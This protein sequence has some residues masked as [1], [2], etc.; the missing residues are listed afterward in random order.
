[1]STL[2]MADRSIRCPATPSMMQRPVTGSFSK[3]GSVIGMTS[4]GFFQLWPPVVDLISVAEPSRLVP[5]KWVKNAYTFPSLSV[6]TVQPS[7]APWLRLVCGGATWW[8]F[9]VTPPSVDTATMGN[10]GK[11]P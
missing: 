7:Y 1:M 5:P 3:H 6:R 11:L 4:C 9:H 8:A 10:S 2:G